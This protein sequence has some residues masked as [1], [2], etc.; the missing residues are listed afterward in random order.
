MGSLGIANLALERKAVVA[1]RPLTLHRAPAPRLKHVRH[2]SLSEDT[3][4]HS[5]W[6]SDDIY[7]IANDIFVTK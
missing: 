2:A 3:S 4:V 7:Q 1:R 5:K 6:S